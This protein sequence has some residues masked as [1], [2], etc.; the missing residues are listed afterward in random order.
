VARIIHFRGRD[1]RDMS[2]VVTGVTTGTGHGVYP[3]TRDI[4]L[5]SRVTCHGLQ[6]Y[7]YPMRWISA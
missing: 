3:V 7:E 6:Q 2:R 1:S 4:S 5:G